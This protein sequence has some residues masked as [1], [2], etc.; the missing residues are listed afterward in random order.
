MTTHT[1]DEHR[2]PRPRR[3]P[4]L[5]R[6]RPPRVAR[7]A[8]V[9]RRDGAGRCRRRAHRRGVRPA[10]RPRHRSAGRRPPTTARRPTR[11]SRRTTTWPTQFELLEA[12]VYATVS[13][14]SRRRAGAGAAQRARADDGRSH[15]ARSPASPTG[16]TRCTRVAADPTPWRRSATPPASTRPAAAPR[17]P[18]GAPDVRGR[19]GALR[20]ARHRRLVGVGPPAVRRHV[21]AD[22]RRVVPRRHRR[23]AAD[24]GGARAGHRT[25]TRRC[26]APR[27]TP[28]WRRG[29]GSPCPC[30]AAMNADQGRGEH[31]QPPPPLGEPARRVAVR[32]RRRPADV[33]RDAG[34]RPRRRSP[35]S[36]A[37]CA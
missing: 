37:G 34:G 2:R 28:S 1:D 30:A 17:R 10:R 31:R 36:G 16:C 6:V 35:T 11:R 32:Q 13:T 18:L 26:A 15:P 12:Y 4:A 7:V 8:L 33:R 5:E 27:T 21:A 3:A 23:A 24:A 9:P 29:R 25:P 22:R 20:P 19:G 14:D